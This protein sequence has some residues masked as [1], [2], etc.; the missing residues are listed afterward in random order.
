MKKWVASYLSPVEAFAT[1]IKIFDRQKVFGCLIV[2]SEALDRL[3]FNG[4]KVKLQPRILDPLIFI[5]QRLPR[6]LDQ[7]SKRALIA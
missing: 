1:R 5:V 3:I 7:L 2:P 6:S 4:S